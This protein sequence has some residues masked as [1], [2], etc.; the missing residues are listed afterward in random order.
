MKA[1]GFTLLE[2]LVV[3]LIIGIL[4][5]IALPKYQLAAEKARAAEGITILRSLRDAQFNYFL[6][7]GKYSN[8]IND[9]D[10]SFPGEDGSYSG[11]PRKESKNFSYAVKNIETE[12]AVASRKP[13]IKDYGLKAQGQQLIC[14]V[15]TSFGR[16]VCKSFGGERVA[17]LVGEQY[18]AYEIK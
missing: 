5:A 14:R 10:I 11:V 2:M 12:L 18:E 13:L 6:T 1:K 16:D 17:D 7:H 9:L 15:Y 4:A 8:D 3:S